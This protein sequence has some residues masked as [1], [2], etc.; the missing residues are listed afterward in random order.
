MRRTLIMGLLLACGCATTTTTAVV[1]P[2][3]DLESD[4]GRMA[5][6]CVLDGPPARLSGYNPRHPID[7]LRYVGPATVIWVNPAPVDR[8]MTADGL[9]Y[10]CDRYL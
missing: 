1:L 8:V 2:N 7:I 10:T 6:R 5:A 3:R 9:I 4:E